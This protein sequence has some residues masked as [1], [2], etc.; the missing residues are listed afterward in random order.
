L[1][2]LENHGADVFL[3]VVGRHGDD[4]FQLAVGSWAVGSWAVGSLAVGQSLVISPLS[5]ILQKLY[6][7][8]HFLFAKNLRYQ[9]NHPNAF[10]QR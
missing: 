5:C 1:L 8:F 9:F 7:V 2:C 4:D 3:L 10:P 6:V